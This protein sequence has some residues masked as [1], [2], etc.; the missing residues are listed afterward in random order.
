MCG[1]T[2]IYNS[3][4]LPLSLSHVDTIIQVIQKNKKN[5]NK[6]YRKYK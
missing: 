6:K 4:N 1:L 3:I 5:F 2:N